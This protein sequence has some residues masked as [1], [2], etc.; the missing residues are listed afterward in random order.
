MIVYKILFFLLNMLEYV[1]SLYFVVI[2]YFILKHQSK[3]PSMEMKAFELALV[4]YITF[5][6]PLL[7]LACTMILLR[8]TTVEPIIQY[9]EKPVRL[10]LEEQMRAK[11]SNS[12]HVERPPQEAF[13]GARPYKDESS[14]IYTSF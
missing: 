10:P 8:Q 2:A 7:G 1:L 4:I 11:E 5:K 12:I 3:M 6:H 9:P 13:T 14:K